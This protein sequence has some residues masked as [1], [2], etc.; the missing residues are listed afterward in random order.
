MKKIENVFWKELQGISVVWP[1]TICLP[2]F[3][4]EEEC[5]VHLSFVVWIELSTS[6]H[7][8]YHSDQSWARH[9]DSYRHLPDGAEAQIPCVRSEDSGDLRATR[10]Q[11]RVMSWR[12]PP[13]M[14]VKIHLVTTEN[15]KKF[16][17][18]LYEI[19]DQSLPDSICTSGVFNQGDQ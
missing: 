8:N 18:M 6:L 16:R 7:N 11:F 15:R 19:Q 14:G 10:S 17:S 12:N 2:S 4:K 5:L 3:L 9:S 13:K 1:F